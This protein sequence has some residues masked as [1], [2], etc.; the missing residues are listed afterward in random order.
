MFSGE[1]MTYQ[2]ATS[3]LNCSVLEGS[4]LICPTSCKSNDYGAKK[5]RFASFHTNSCNTEKL[6]YDFI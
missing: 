3:T 2:P 4:F 1:K 6:R 5:L